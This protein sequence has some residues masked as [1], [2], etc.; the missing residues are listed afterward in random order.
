MQ[1]R[2]IM[3]LILFAMT[4]AFAPLGHWVDRSWYIA[5]LVAAVTGILL[6]FTERV[7][8]RFSRNHRTGN[9]SS[10][11]LDGFSDFHDDH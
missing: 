7:E 11:D 6:M 1:V 2:E 8:R 4:F 9:D 3:G 10:P 5:A